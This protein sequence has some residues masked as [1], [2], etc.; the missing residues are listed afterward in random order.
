MWSHA[1]IGYETYSWSP[2]GELALVPELKQEVV[3]GMTNIIH[4][5]LSAD[6]LVP[7]WVLGKPAAFDITVTSPLNPS[8]FTAEARVSSL[9][10]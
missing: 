6:M 1:T 7:D 2:A 10:S 9:G 5:L 4:D 8:T 3:L